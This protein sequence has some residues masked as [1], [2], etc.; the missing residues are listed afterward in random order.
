MLATAAVL[1]AVVAGGG[2]VDETAYA[3]VLVDRLSLLV[4]RGCVAIDAGETGIV[5]GNLVAIVAHRAVVGNG[6]VRVI[7]SGAQPA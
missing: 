4:C 5:G 7:E 2:A 6:E 3:V 1:V